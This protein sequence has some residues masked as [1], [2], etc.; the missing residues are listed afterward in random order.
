MYQLKNGNEVLLPEVKQLD[1]LLLIESAGPDTEADKLMGLLRN[2]PDI[3]LAQII[4][5]DRLK[6]SS[7]LLV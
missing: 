6:N 4:P 7:H 3:Q 5:A 2:M 1:Y